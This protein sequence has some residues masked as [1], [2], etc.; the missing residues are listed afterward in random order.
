VPT[1]ARP[2]R[3]EPSR[4]PLI[5]LTTDFGVVDPFVGTMK[6]VMLAIAP[7]ATI[8]DLTHE[9]P[10]QDVRAGAYLLHSAAGYFPRGTIHVVVVDPGVGTSRRALLVETRDGFF[11]APDNGVLTLV[12][13][14]RRVVSV[15]DVSRSPV[16][17]QP[18]SRTFHGRDLF[19]PV[20]AHLA[21]GMPLARLGRRVR[22]FAR[23]TLPVPGRR[24]RT[25]VGEVVWIDRFGNLITNLTEQEVTR[26][27]GRER[28][29]GRGAR[30][31]ARARSRGYRGRGVS[32]T[33]D[34]RAVPLLDAYGQALP[35]TVL[36]LV[37]SAGL[38]E[39][40][41][42]HG[43]AAVMLG[44]TCGTR[45]SIAPAGA[46]GRS[47]RAPVARRRARPGRKQP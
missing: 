17:R 4:P 13:P 11:V 28:R 41:V 26:L 45:I 25:L 9:V 46:A 16:R 6:G 47:R 27:T 29:G 7:H 19:A 34:G 44:A 5:T 37:N 12:A 32:V 30:G 21:S 33:I 1:V 31:A 2:R 40:A 36:A 23:L 43:S 38:V 8:V 15:W 22:G 42:N 18:V 14:P 35:G 10:P 20:A 3:R 39:I 24:G